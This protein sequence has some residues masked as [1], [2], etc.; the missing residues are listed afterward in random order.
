M[1]VFDI[2]YAFFARE[3]AASVRIP[4][5]LRVSGRFQADLPISDNK[6]N[7]IGYSKISPTIYCGKFSKIYLLAL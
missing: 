2:R 4:G 1:P 7:V 5:D 3:N 6:A